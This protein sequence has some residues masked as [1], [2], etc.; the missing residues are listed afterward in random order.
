MFLPGQEAEFAAYEADHPV[1]GGGWIRP[2]SGILAWGIVE[3]VDDYCATAF[4]YCREPQPVPRLD[5]AAATKDIA[6]LPFEKP[7]P[8]EPLIPLLLGFV[9]GGSAPG[10]A[11][12]P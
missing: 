2:G 10:S 8:L 11:E 4:V 1:A 12:S 5:V 6:R 9:P 3:R 7:D